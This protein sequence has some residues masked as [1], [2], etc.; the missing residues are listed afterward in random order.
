[1][2]DCSLKE[3]SEIFLDSPED[4]W[5]IIELLSIKKGFLIRRTGDLKKMTPIRHSRR[6]VPSMHTGLTT[7]LCL[8]P[9]ELFPPANP[10]TNGPKKYGTEAQV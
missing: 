10:G 3:T 5:I 2:K 6:S 7:F 8:R 9:E 4:E 1:M